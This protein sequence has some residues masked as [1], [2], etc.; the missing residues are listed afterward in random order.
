MVLGWCWN[1]FD[2]IVAFG[3]WSLDYTSWP[4]H[5]H[6]P[7]VQLLHAAQNDRDH[8]ALSLVSWALA[9]CGQLRYS[10]SVLSMA[11]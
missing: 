2:I 10:A 3:F 6:L 1:Q 9:P 7:V 4:D 8:D 11:T 5:C